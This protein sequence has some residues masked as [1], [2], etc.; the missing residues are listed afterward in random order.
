MA[1]IA[2]PVKITATLDDVEALLFA[3]RAIN[4]QMP[5]MMVGDD[6]EHMCLLSDHA[7][8]MREMLEE[9]Y[10]REKTQ[11]TIRLTV[12][13]ARAIVQMWK[14]PFGLTPYLALAV[15]ELTGKIHKMHLDGTWVLPPTMKAIK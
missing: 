9:Q 8:E 11:Y 5:A 13:Q 6:Y 7:L 1:T 12:A 14:M 10:W 3:F 4:D 15:R 2:T